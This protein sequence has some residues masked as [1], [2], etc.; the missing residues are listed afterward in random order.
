MAK[1]TGEKTKAVP[2]VR[3]RCINTTTD[4]RYNY[5]TAGQEYVVR[6]DHPCMR[7]FK[8]LETVKESDFDE[9][10]HEVERVRRAQAQARE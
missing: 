1:A 7:H 8:K 3:V 6:A 5:Y 10:Q 4:S 9:E 2:L